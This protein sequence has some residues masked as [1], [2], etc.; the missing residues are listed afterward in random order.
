[1]PEFVYIFYYESHEIVDHDYNGDSV[2]ETIE[3]TIGAFYDYDFGKNY[4]QE[5]YKTKTIYNRKLKIMDA[6]Q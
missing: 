2:Y 6:V 1:M 4:C 3:N 5:K